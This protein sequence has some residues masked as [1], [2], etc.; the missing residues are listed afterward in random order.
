MLPTAWKSAFTSLASRFA[1]PGGLLA[2]L[3]DRLSVTKG[4]MAGAGV[5]LLVALM[6][7]WL[8]S[9]LLYTAAILFAVACAAT[10]IWNLVREVETIR[11]ERDALRLQLNDLRTAMAPA[12]T[13]S[14]PIPAMEAGVGLYSPPYGRNS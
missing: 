3:T 1:A 2:Q 4:S 8:A 10:L 14:R 11:D 7:A 12:R 13:G 6:A 9:S 5:A